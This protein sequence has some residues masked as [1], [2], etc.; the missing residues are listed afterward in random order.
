MD[1]CRSCGGTLED[2]NESV[3]VCP[4]CG[5]ADCWPRLDYLIDFDV[6]DSDPDSDRGTGENSAVEDTS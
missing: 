4:W 3:I 5:E 1:R 6:D 2:C